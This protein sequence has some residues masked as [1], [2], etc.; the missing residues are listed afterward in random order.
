MECGSLS[1]SPLRLESATEKPREVAELKEENKQLLHFRAQQNEI[2]DEITTL[3]SQE[4]ELRKQQE[5]FERDCNAK[6]AKSR[7]ALCSLTF[8]TCGRMRHS[9]ALQ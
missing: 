4:D 9:G 2:L 8:R 5:L 7:A 1:S 6:L 3:R